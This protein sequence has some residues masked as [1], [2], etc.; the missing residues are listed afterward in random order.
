MSITSQQI[1]S[2]L[3]EVA[4]ID[5]AGVDLRVYFGSQLDEAARQRYCT[6]RFG[7]CAGDMLYAELAP[8]SPGH[9]AILVNDGMV[10]RAIYAIDKPTADREW[11]VDQTMVA[12]AHHE[13]GHHLDHPAPNLT[14]PLPAHFVAHFAAVRGQP[15]EPSPA[16][17]WEGHGPQ[18]VRVCRHLQWR[19]IEAGHLALPEMLTFAGSVYGLSSAQHYT[20]T[21]AN[22]PQNRRGE[23]I[24]SIAASPLPPAM[25]ALYGADWLS[26]VKSLPITT[27]AE[28]A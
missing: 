27:A 12:I 6:G 9:M 5:L 19:A 16:Y 4:P 7:G 10:R 25:A 1:E 28:A 15:F 20:A 13:L 22:E 24:R 2:M 18:F 23:S 14:S 3:R 11:M 17:P 26:W 21:M 8:G